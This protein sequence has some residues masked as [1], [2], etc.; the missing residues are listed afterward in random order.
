MYETEDENESPT[1]YSLNAHQPAFELGE[2]KE[3]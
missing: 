1:T 2:L 3:A